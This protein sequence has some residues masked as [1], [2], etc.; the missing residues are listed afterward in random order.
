MV[1]QYYDTFFFHP[2]IMVLVNKRLITILTTKRYHN[3]VI[4][5]Y[6]H[7]FKPYLLIT[8]KRVVDSIFHYLIPISLKKLSFC[9]M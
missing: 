4:T 9:K 8:E 2:T 3:N 1:D 7:H 5:R 6:K